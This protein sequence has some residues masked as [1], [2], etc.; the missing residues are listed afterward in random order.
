[1]HW[2][3]D[4]IFCVLPTLY[5]S[6][7]YN[8]IDRYLEIWHPA[9]LMTKHPYVY[10]YTYTFRGQVNKNGLYS[11]HADMIKMYLS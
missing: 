10:T 8:Y 6:A 1:M 11:K 9:T 7:S 5:Y 4:L 3:Q 2:S